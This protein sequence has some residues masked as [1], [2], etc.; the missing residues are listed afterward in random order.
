MIAV[1]VRERAA[2]GSRLENV[3]AVA[4]ATGNTVVSATAVP[5]ASDATAERQAMI[6]EAAYYIAER[7]GFEPGH[8]LEDWLC[9][10]REMNSK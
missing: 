4:P 2:K 10:E 9:A 8:E 7:R 6:A 3:G 1:S 5:V